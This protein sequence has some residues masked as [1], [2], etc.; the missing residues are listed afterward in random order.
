VTVPW[1]DVSTAYYATGIPDIEVYAT[2]PS[3]AVDAMRL[4]RP[5]T[6]LLGLRSVER[7]AEGVVDAVVSGPTPDERARSR[8]R[9]YAE[10]ESDGGRRVGARLRTGDTYDLTARVAVESARRV[11]AGEAPDGF[12]TPATAFGPNYVVEFDGVEREFLD[13]P[14]ADVV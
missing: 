14:D 10:A 12:E 11:L 6:P 1:G 5:L 3:F 13:L 9:I 8:A 4:S 2:V 7:V